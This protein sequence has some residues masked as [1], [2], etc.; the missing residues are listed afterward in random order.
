MADLPLLP[1]IEIPE[2]KVASWAAWLQAQNEKAIEHQKNTVTPTNPFYETFVVSW[3][4]GYPYCG[5]IGGEYTY[6][7]T[8]TSMGFVVKAINAITGDKFDLS[9]YD[10]W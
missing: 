9:D 2:D 6:E 7:I 10:S 4:M 5:A 8:P 1:A 3:E